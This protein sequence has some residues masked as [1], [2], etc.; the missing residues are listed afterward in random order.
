MTDGA[1]D[2]LCDFSGTSQIAKDVWFRWTPP[3]NGEYTISTCFLAVNDSKIAIY[4]GD[5]CTQSSIIA[6]ND[7]ADVEG[8]GLQS[9][10]TAPGL[11]GGEPYLIRIG[12]F[13][14][15]GGDTGLFLITGEEEGG[16]NY[17]T[18]GINLDGEEASMSF[19]GTTSVAANNFELVADGVSSL[20]QFGLFVMGD[21]QTRFPFGEGFL[22]IQPN[23]N[24]YRLIPVIAFSNADQ[25]TRPLDFLTN[26]TSNVTPA[27][28]WNFQFWYRDLGETNLSDAIKVCFGP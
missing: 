12:S 11:V 4:D 3:C 10:I 14:G 27:S 22:C 2:A 19:S 20:A 28:P 15:A 16:T 25:V 6:C 9:E 7:D 5:S 17:C 13:P 18:G 26:P 1:P 8:C 23:E 24:F 21:T